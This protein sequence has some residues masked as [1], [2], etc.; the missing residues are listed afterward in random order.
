MSPAKDVLPVI[1]AIIN[2]RFITC[3]ILC[4]LALSS[5]FCEALAKEERPPEKY[6]SIAVS[7]RTISYF[8][9]DDHTKRRFGRLRWR[10][11]LSLS[12]TSPLFGGLSGLIMGAQGKNFIAVT[13]QGNW[14]RARLIYKGDALAGLRD[15]KIGPLR[16]RNGRPLKHKRHQDAEGVTLVK[17]TPRKGEVLIS[18]ERN[19]RIGRFPIDA[20][21]IGKPK[22]YLKLP[23][24]LAGVTR[25]KGLEALTV[26]RAGRYEGRVLTFAERKANK[27]G[28][29]EGWILAGR[30]SKPLRL[31]RIGGFDVTDLASLPSGDVIVLE[32]RFR[33]S[34]GVRMR[35]RLITHAELMSQNAILGQTLLE[36][37]GRF[38][39][40]NM[41][42][43][44]VHKDS[45]GKTIITLVSDD[46]FSVLQRTLLLQ[47]EYVEK[48]SALRQP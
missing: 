9:G 6:G 17:G 8:Q 46:N 3:T 18:F 16:A 25:N 1:S 14:I 31:K 24:G 41:E 13:D 20:D 4:A 40:D 10:G 11:G 35:L 7:A 34:E 12:S 5:S 38:S 36:A 44:A 21:G 23:K 2:A 22:Y 32:R 47:F 19:H 39:I 28:H 27:D 48:R 42:G 15:V 37:D 45:D 29:L 33:W 26:L 43:V 30:R